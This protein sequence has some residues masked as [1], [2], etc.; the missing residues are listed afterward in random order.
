MLLFLTVA[1]TECTDLPTPTMGGSVSYN[2]GT[3]DSRPVNTVATYTCTSGY[4]LSGDTTRTCGSD[5]QWSGSA[6][7]CQGMLI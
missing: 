6:P 1:A 5:G 2:M 3:V 4:T 7:T